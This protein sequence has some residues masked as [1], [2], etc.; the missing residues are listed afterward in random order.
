MLNAYL[1]ELSVY[2]EQK[3][4]GKQFSFSGPWTSS[5]CALKKTQ[6]R[7]QE[8]NQVN[9]KTTATFMDPADDQP[10]LG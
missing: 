8:G 4:F 1:K 7:E 5:K 10:F 2:T 6:M 9:R 3:Q